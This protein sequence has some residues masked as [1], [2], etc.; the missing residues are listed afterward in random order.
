[1]PIA[2]SSASSWRER[3]GRCSATSATRSATTTGRSSWSTGGHLDEFRALFGDERQSYQDA[4]DRHY[5]VGAASDRPTGRRRTSASTP[6][7]TRGRIGRRRSRTTSTSVP[8]WR[9]RVR[10][11]STSVTHRDRRATGPGRRRSVRDRRH[12]ATLVVAHDGAQCDVTLD[13]AERSVPV[14]AVGDGRRQA[15]LRAPVDRADRRL[16]GRVA[17]LEP[18]E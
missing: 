5:G 7:C 6:P 15:G 10:S 16:C 1:M 12:R 14:R 18:G 8:V 2:S 17:V 13:R 11:V 3:T 9:R 4:L